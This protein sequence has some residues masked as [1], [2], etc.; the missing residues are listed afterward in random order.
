MDIKRITCIENLKGEFFIDTW[1]NL[2]KGENFE[3]KKTKT[4]KSPQTG[5]EYKTF[6]LKNEEVK[7]VMIH[8]IVAT[9]FIPNDDP[10]KVFIKHKDGNRTNNCVDNLEW[11]AP[12]A[13]DVSGFN[14]KRK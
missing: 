10:L 14:T 6:V 8:E 7:T 2:Y 5:Y 12:S 1:W 11:F 3:L 13:N 9:T 4:Y